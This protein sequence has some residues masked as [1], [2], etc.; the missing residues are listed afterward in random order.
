MKHFKPKAWVLPQT[1]LIIGTYNAD[2][3]PNAMNTAWGGQWDSNEIMIS[4]GSHATTDNLN[5]CGDFTIAFATAQ[6]ITAADYVGITSARH[7]HDKIT[8]PGCENETV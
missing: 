2:G 8:M 1:V 7:D 4:M 3:T 5:R 6:T